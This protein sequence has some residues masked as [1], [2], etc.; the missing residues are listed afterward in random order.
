MKKLFSVIIPV[1]NR[2]RLIGEVSSLRSGAN[3]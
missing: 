2:E 1:Y 3:T